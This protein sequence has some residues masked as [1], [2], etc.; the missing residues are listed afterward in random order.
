MILRATFL[1]VNL[2]CQILIFNFIVIDLGFTGYHRSEQ[3]LLILCVSGERTETVQRNDFAF[4]PSVQQLARGD[5]RDNQYGIS[6]PLL[7]KSHP[8]G[9]SSSIYLAK[10][11]QNIFSKFLVA[12]IIGDIHGKDK[13]IF[14]CASFG[15]LCGELVGNFLRSANIFWGSSFFF[16]I[17][18]LE[19]SKLS[20]SGS[21]T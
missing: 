7:S 19:I 2:F 12:V 4:S 11:L 9:E 10:L 3:M 21:K 14:N 13:E 15:K 6:R 20:F 18:A 5:N 17:S 1:S 8:G 16:T